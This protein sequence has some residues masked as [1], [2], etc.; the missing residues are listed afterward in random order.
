[1]KKTIFVYIFSSFLV[2]FMLSACDNATNT[3][4]ASQAEEAQA[5]SIIVEDAD[6][7]V[8]AE[9]VDLVLLAYMNN[10]LQ[11]HM[12]ALAINATNS[13]S[14][15]DLA[16]SIVDAEEEMRIKLE[17]LA[18]ATNTNLPEAIGVDQKMKIDSI[19]SLPQEQ[20][21]EAYVTKVI[22]EYKEN[23][24]R[25]NELITK[26]D[27]PITAGVVADIKDMQEEQMRKAESLLE[28]LS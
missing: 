4:E 8:A 11:Y 27:N 1:M 3:N 19:D 13:E 15:R 24:E 25:L 9:P 17:E 12:G 18:Q 7:E 5:D 28:E 22:D 20:F 6:E 2:I 23:T 14:V 10:R 21:D 26:G 16:Q